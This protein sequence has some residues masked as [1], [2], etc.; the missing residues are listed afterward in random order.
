[1]SS[2][3]DWIPDQQIFPEVALRRLLS[4]HIETTMCLILT[5]KNAPIQVLNDNLYP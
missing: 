4:R 3:W 2:S 5:E 1:M